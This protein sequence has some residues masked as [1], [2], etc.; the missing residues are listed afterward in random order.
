MIYQG[1]QPRGGPG[2]GSVGSV[3]VVVN[4]TRVEA[5]PLRRQNLFAQ[6]GKLVEDGLDLLVE[7][8]LCRFRGASADHRTND[9]IYAS[10]NNIDSA[11]WPG[12]TPLLSKGSS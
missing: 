5:D 11:S 2:F 12:C 10:V 4:L 8:G 3:I 6:A 1:T 9:V 7:R